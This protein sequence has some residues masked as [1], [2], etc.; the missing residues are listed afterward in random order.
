MLIAQSF[1]EIR[2]Y[3]GVAER[4]GVHF[5]RNEVRRSSGCCGSLSELIRKVRALGDG[6]FYLPLNRWPA[7]KERVEIRKPWVVM[8]S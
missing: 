4:T 3:E 1:D 5:Q 8:A 6:T 7:E 2:V